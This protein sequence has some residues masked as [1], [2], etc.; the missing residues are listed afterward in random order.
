MVHASKADIRNPL[1]CAHER[2]RFAFKICFYLFDETNISNVFPISAF[3]QMERFSISL[4]YNSFSANLCT[5]ISGTRIPVSHPPER[6]FYNNRCVTSDSKFQKYDPKIFMSSQKIFIA[7]L[8]PIPAFILDKGIIATEIY[9]HW[10][11]AL[12]TVWNQFCWNTHIFLF[13]QHPTNQFLIFI[14]FLV[15]W[16]AALQQP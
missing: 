1:R 11:T 9:S 2:S 3:K 8:C 14:R 16:F 5:H 12:W 15:T 10:T 6:I 13:L 4:G 7:I